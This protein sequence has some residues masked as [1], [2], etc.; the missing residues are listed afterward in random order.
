MASCRTQQHNYRRLVGGK[1]LKLLGQTL[2]ESFP[3]IVH[4]RR[5]DL[6]LFEELSDSYDPVNH[7]LDGF[8]PD[9]PCFDNAFEIQRLVAIVKG[10]LLEYVLEGCLRLLERLQK[11]D[12]QETFSEDKYLWQGAISMHKYGVV[13]LG[14]RSDCRQ[15]FLPALHGNERQ[16]QKIEAFL[17]SDRNATRAINYGV[18]RWVNA[19]NI[20]VEHPGRLIPPRAISTTS[21]HHIA[22]RPVDFEGPTSKMLDETEPQWDLHD[23]SHHTVSSLSPSL[24]GSKY[25]THLVKLPPRLTALI[26]S[27]GMKTGDPKPRCSDGVVFSELLTEQF[28]SEMKLAKEMEE[29]PTYRAL[30][31][32][33][34]STLSRYL[35]GEQ[36]LLHPTSGIEISMQK[37]ITVEQLA[38]LAQNKAYELTASELEQRVLTRGGPASDARDEMDMMS[39]AE[40]VRFLA[41]NKS[42]MFF[43]VRNTIKHRAHKLAYQLVAAQ[44]IEWS[45]DRLSSQDRELVELTI[46][47]MRYQGWQQGEVPNLWQAII[48][49]HD[50]TG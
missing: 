21:L 20:T 40:R 2:Q 35:L 32:R 9:H 47:A 31:E 43:E 49:R 8:C 46:S 19:S 1:Q 33:I 10:Q 41:A 48:D 14:S 39:L 12:L 42:W 17:S 45:E 37:P 24:Y 4:E 50:L 18:H 7:W 28:H 36:K 15:V 29:K 27:P 44:M 38:V 22:V 23:F 11:S 13:Y 6:A 5:E 3:Q 34:A 25:F 30:T 16:F 26:R